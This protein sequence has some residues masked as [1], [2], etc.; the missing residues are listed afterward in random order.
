MEA[1]VGMTRN[2]AIEQRK[3]FASEGGYNNYINTISKVRAEFGKINDVNFTKLSN[4]IYKNGEL[5]LSMGENWRKTQADIVNS[6]TIIK[7]AYREVNGE[8]ITV[9]EGIYKVSEVLKTFDFTLTQSAEGMTV[10]DANAE[11]MRDLNHYAKLHNLETWENYQKK[12]GTIEIPDALV[13]YFGKELISI[14]KKK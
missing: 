4:N 2:M 11:F 7:L 13:P 6:T 14:V 5:I 9:V 8:L 10:A 3:A 12:D 1:F